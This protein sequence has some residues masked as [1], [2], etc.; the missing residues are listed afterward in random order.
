LGQT[1]NRKRKERESWSRA[2]VLG[3]E[4]IFRR[5]KTDKASAKERSR[6]RKK[7]GTTLFGTSEKT[8]EVLA[9]VPGGKTAKE[10]QGGGCKTDFNQK[11][12]KKRGEKWLKKRVPL[13]G[14][15]SGTKSKADRSHF[16]KKGGGKNRTGY[17]ERNDSVELNSVTAIK[18]W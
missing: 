18:K 9:T 15:E 7:G 13:G 10:P 14:V 3:G 17:R 4:D 2:I 11:K 8:A 1:S 12:M 16:R 6:G 5:Q